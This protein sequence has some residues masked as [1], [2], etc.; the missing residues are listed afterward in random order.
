MT[1]LVFN[2]WGSDVQVNDTGLKDYI[3]LDAK[4]VLATQGRHVQRAFGKMHLHVVER[5]VN[6]MMRGGTGEKISGRIIRGRGGTGKK[7]KM[8]N[9]VRYAFE[10]IS[11]KTGK[12]PIELLV[13]AIEN[14]APREETTRVQYGGII[15]P[16]AVDVSP[17]RRLDLSLRNI[18]HAATIRSFDKKKKT[19]EALAEEII[20][21]SQRDATS[22]AIARRVETE[23]ISRSSR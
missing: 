15:V 1:F 17:Q 13:R 14:A 3:C 21:A 7:T 22:F 20:L 23:R 11:K 9:V 8:Y 6:N 16:I 18:A 4:L 12:N 19:S 5:L 2:R 10:T